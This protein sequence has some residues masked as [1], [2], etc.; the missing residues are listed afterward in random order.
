[1]GTLEQRIIKEAKIRFGRIYPIDFQFTS[2]PGSTPVELP[3]RS[4]VET[5]FCIR[6][7]VIDFESIGDAPHIGRAVTEIVRIELMKTGKYEVVKRTLLNKILEEQKFQLSDRVDPST[8]VQLGKVVG[9][10]LILTG[11]VAKIGSSYTI[12]ARFIDIKTGTA[13]KTKTIRGYSRDEL[14]YMSIKLIGILEQEVKPAPV[15]PPERFASQLSAIPEWLNQTGIMGDVILAVGT[16]P[17]MYNPELQRREA[18][19]QARVE[20][21]RIIRT[22]VQAMQENFAEKATDLMTDQGQSEFLS[23]SVSREGADALLVE[24]QVTKYYTDPQTAIMYAPKRS[25]EKRML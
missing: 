22:K 21:A 19:H 9:A 7:A 6:V 14:T 16:V 23:P 24:V 5:G 2:R 15:E 10:D 13:K 17:K 3:K 11:S 20:I 12:N 18:A 8:A 25:W 1:M 4:T